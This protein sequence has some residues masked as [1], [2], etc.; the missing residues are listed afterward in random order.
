M[1][2]GTAVRLILDEI[3]R[4]VARKKNIQNL[5]DDASPS[6]LRMVYQHHAFD[7]K[8]GSEKN[9]GA[10]IIGSCKY[11]SPLRF[12]PHLPFCTPDSE[13]R[14]GKGGMGKVSSRS[15]YVNK[16]F[17]I[18]SLF[19]HPDK[20]NTATRAIPPPHSNTFSDI[21]EARD[22]LL[23]HPILISLR[24]TAVDVQQDDEIKVKLLLSE[25]REQIS[26]EIDALKRNIV[27]LWGTAR[28]EHQRRHYVSHFVM[29]M[30]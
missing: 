27:Y 21:T 7:K 22:S 3:N 14:V 29:N 12:E 25:E 24:H 9:S 30:I 15:H 8:S 11:K 17:R 28:N 16:F 19:L 1:R 4:L 20:H 5:I 18:A 10:D 6:F 13:Q 23:L 2:S 26:K